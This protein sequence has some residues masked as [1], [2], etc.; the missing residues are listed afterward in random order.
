MSSNRST[1]LLEELRGLLGQLCEGSLDGPGYRR[2]ETLVRSGPAARQLYIETILLHGELRWASVKSPND[3]VANSADSTGEDEF[4]P[5]SKLALPFPSV[6]YFSTNLDPGSPDVP[7][8]PAKSAILADPVADGL[9]HQP[10]LSSLQRFFLRGTGFMSRAAAILILVGTLCTGVLLG[11]LA[12]A[13]VPQ[14]RDDGSRANSE[15]T[16]LGS[17][18]AGFT[19]ALFHSAKQGSVNPNSDSPAL[20]VTT[21]QDYVHTVSNDTLALFGSAPKRVIWQLRFTGGLLDS[22]PG[23]R[24]VVLGLRAG[25]TPASNLFLPGSGDPS[26]AGLWV[27]LT[28]GVNI[29]PYS[30]KLAKHGNLVFVNAAGEA[31]LL[32]TWDWAQFDMSSHPNITVNLD[33]SATHYALSFDQEVTNLTGALSG[34]LPSSAPTSVRIGVFDQIGEGDVP[35]SVTVDRIAISDRPSSDVQRSRSNEVRAKEVDPQQ[36]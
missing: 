9:G 7:G 12:V 20:P 13:A 3:I 6:H 32:A 11:A 10:I 25:A 14:W 35:G 29:T 8:V 4:G 18:G 22:V 21:P 24:R 2:I 23:N 30:I 33:T 16:L 17:T 26:Q 15:V 36:K 31:L 28:N 19:T 34:E 27:F 5:K 1:D